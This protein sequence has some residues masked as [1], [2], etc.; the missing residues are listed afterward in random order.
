MEERQELPPLSFQELHGVDSGIVFH[1]SNILYH[2]RSEIQDILVIQTRDYGR[3][4]VLDRLVMTT[5]RDEFYYHEAL[6]HPVMQHHPAPHR[7][8][9]LGGGDGGTLREVLRYPEVE[10]VTLVEIDEKVI[11]VAHEFFP[12]LARSFRDPRVD[13]RIEDAYAFVQHAEERFDVAIL[14]T[15]DPVGPAQVFYTK[16]FFLALRERLEPVSVISV[17]AE[18][19]HFHRKRIVDLYRILKEVFST[20]RPYTAPVPSYP[21]GT[22]CFMLA[23][24]QPSLPAFRKEV[25]EAHELQFYHEGLHPALF[26]LPAFLK[27]LLE[28]A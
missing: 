14:D 25:P 13:V 1:T 27:R 19:V 24:P 4:L 2:A 5:E 21:G 12:E 18:S 17:Q 22:W 28:Q 11:E 23:S 7:V 26:Q 3:V 16:D 10:Q 6:V 15:S 8:L 20:V 9:I